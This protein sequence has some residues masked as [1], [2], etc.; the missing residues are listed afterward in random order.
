MEFAANRH[1]LRG[2]LGHAAHER[3]F[4]AGLHRIHRIDAR[5]GRGV[6]LQPC[7]R[8]SALP[9]VSGIF[10]AE[11]LLRRQ[12]RLREIERRAAQVH[13]GGAV[14]IARVSSGSTTILIAPAFAKNAVARFDTD[15]GRR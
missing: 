3:A 7:R 15:N 4:E 6:R 8:E 12:H 5:G 11:A 10:A 1:D 13:A 14:E 9:A 2:A